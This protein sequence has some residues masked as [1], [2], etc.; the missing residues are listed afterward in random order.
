MQLVS[1]KKSLKDSVKAG[2][3]I[4]CESLLINKELFSVKVQ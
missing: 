4:S 1:S 3:L 2:Q